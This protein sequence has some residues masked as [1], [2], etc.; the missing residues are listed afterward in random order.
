MATEPQG[1]NGHGTAGILGNF[2]SEDAQQMIE[3]GRAALDQALDTASQ[4][5]RERPIVCLAG[6]LAFGYVLGK[7]VSR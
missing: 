7:I 6:A 1:S 3:Q 2:N 4:F 5:I